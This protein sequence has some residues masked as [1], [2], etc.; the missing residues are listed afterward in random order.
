MSKVFEGYVD[1]ITVFDTPMP[2]WLFVYLAR[3]ASTDR[4]LAP[5][6]LH[7]IARA[8]KRYARRHPNGIRNNF[9]DWI[10]I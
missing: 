6:V 4:H 9:T 1:E 10:H 5:K 3:I 8:A 7:N 2:D